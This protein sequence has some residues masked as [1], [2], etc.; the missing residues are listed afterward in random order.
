MFRLSLSWQHY[1]FV[2]T[3]KLFVTFNE[4]PLFPWFMPKVSWTIWLNYSESLFLIRLLAKH[5]T[6]RKDSDEADLV[7]ARQANVRCPQIVIA[8]Y[9][10]RL[11][12]HSHDDDD[13]K[14]DKWTDISL[15][16]WW[17]INILDSSSC[18]CC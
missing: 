12:W 4:Y 14:E 9:E 8:F 5:F 16:S 1:H 13:N 7:P 15:G 11:T 10:E 2:V 6:S 17:E 18:I 3:E